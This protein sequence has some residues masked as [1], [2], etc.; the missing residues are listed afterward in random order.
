M[1][2]IYGQPGAEIQ[3]LHRCPSGI[4]CFSDVKIQLEKS[5]KQLGE[6]K[7]QFFDVLPERI[8]NEKIKLDNLKII[9]IDVEKKWDETIVTIRKSIESNRW[10]FWKY[11]DLTIKQH[12]SKPKAIRNAD[13]DIQQQ[14]SI[15]N[16]L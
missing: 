5:Q 15:I 3:L 2:I 13:N 12:Y 14:M 6:E 9:R 4:N 7:K 1:A 11:I 10:K 16:A 8:Q